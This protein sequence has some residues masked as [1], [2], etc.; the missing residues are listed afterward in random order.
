MNNPT[1]HKEGFHSP[2]KVPKTGR[3]SPHEYGRQNQDKNSSKSNFLE[4]TSYAYITVLRYSSNGPYHSSNLCDW[5]NENM[6][7]CKPKTPMSKDCSIQIH[8][9]VAVAPAHVGPHSTVMF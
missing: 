5:K 7:G 6:Y 8:A 9:W 1:G 4:G 3:N 2:E